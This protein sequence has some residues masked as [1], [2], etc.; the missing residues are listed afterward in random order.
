MK[1]FNEQKIKLWVKLTQKK[2]EYLDIE[3]FVDDA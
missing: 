2:M 1:E 3:E